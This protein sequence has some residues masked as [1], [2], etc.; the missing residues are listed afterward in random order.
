MKYSDTEYTITK[1]TDETIKN[2][3]HDFVT[4]TGTRYA[5][6]PT[7]VTTYGLVNNSYSGDIQAVITMDDL[8][9]P[10]S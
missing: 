4:I 1:R 2:K 9:A 8:F 6:H 3:I 7:L 5:I 10:V